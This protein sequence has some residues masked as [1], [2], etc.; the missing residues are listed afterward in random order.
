[1]KLYSHPRSRGMRCH[2]TL[3]ELQVPYEYVTIDIHA[4]ASRTPEFLKIHPLGVVPALEDDGQ[5]LIESGAICVYLADKYP[6]KALGAGNQPGEY[7]QWCFYTFGS[8]EPA[9]MDVLMHTM[10]LPEDQRAPSVA[11]R[12]RQNLTKV[13]THLNT[14]MKDRSYLLGE[15]FSVADILLGGTLGWAHSML[16][17][18]DYPHLLT[19]I[20][21]IHQRPAFQTA[22]QAMA[23][24]Q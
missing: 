5:I 4:G 11:E 12:G 21:R 8:L 6:E 23:A 19:Y 17:M 1:M 13:L 22:A 14:V 10:F 15:R 7:Y 2:W 20:E 24:A 3:E 16:P 18:N 9:L